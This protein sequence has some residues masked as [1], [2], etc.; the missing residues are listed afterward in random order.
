MAGV[1]WR[2]QRDRHPESWCP[3]LLRR[4]VPAVGEGRHPEG[5][6]SCEGHLVAGQRA[7]VGAT[8]SLRTRRS[9]RGVAGPG[10]RAPRQTPF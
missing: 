10:S 3:V 4:G 8:L 1:A 5:P 2:G 9:R 6:L 7:V